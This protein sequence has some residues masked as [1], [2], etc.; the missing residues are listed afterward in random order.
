MFPRALR[1]LLEGARTPPGREEGVVLS[2]YRANP[3]ESD[4]QQVSEWGRGALG[5]QWEHVRGS[6]CHCHGVTPLWGD[7][8]RRSH[9][10]TP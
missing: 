7:P 2:S 5:G 8:T 4:P 6:G 3:P 10:M 1:A 9:E